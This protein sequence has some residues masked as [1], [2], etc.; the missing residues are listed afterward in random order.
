MSFHLA[1]WAGLRAAEAQT[2]EELE[3]AAGLV[4]LS[5][6]VAAD[7]FERSEDGFLAAVEGTNAYNAYLARELGVSWRAG[8]GYTSHSGAR[9]RRHGAHGFFSRMCRSMGVVP[10]L[11]GR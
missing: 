11:L 2:Q 9:A 1:L 5:E 10:H 8:G 7:A 6:C 3:E 4:F